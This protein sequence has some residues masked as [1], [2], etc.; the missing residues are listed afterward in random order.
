MAFG[1][2]YTS[3][4]CSPARIS[5]YA[6]KPKG[7]PPSAHSLFPHPV[8]VTRIR[9]ELGLRSSEMYSS[10]WTVL[11][12]SSGPGCAHSLQEETGPFVCW[13]IYFFLLEVVK[14]VKICKETLLDKNIALKF[15]MVVFQF[16]LP[17]KTEGTA[18]SIQCNTTKMYP[19]QWWGYESMM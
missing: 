2:G 11:G 7:L 19:L 14:N 10:T 3:T 13:M 6:L 5:K 4:Y 17:L 15:N 9:A 8:S 12:L 16:F 1:Q 18:C